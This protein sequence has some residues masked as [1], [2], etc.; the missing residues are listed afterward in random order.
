MIATH[1]LIE[2]TSALLAAD[3]LT[4]APAAG[5]CKV[6]LI[7]GNFS[8]GPATTFAALTPAAF[9]GSAAKSSA[10]GAQKEGRD[11]QT[12]RRKILFVEPIGGWTWE[13]TADPAAPETVTGYC[14]TDATD[15]ITFG[16]ALLDAPV[17]VSKNGDL[18][19]IGEISLLLVAK[20]WE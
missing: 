12:G 16:S 6:H 17:T 14:V 1:V 20:P 10:M 7:T 3:D 2:A 19:S 15:G 4:I 5:G 13:A 11:P 8:P 18:V 9:A